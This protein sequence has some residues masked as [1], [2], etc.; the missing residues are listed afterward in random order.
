MKQE[1]SKTEKKKKDTNW[2]NVTIVGEES[3]ITFRR[4][5][6]EFV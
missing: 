1:K 3:E 5:V 4:T 6:F 2:V